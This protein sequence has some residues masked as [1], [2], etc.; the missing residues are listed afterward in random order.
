M[1]M[2]D[3]NA[4]IAQGQMQVVDLVTPLSMEHRSHVLDK[5]WQRSSEDQIM[6]PQGA[7]L[8]SLMTSMQMIALNGVRKFTPSGAFTCYTANKGMS[9]IDYALVQH[10]EAQ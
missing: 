6:N 1:L 3:L 5:M 9:I 10:E 4:C 7:A 2:G 8:M